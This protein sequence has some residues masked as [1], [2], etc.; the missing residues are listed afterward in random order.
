MQAVAVSATRSPPSYLQRGT[1]IL[2]QVLRDHF[3]R[4]AANYD[5]RYAKDLGNFRLDRISRVATRFLTCGD[6]P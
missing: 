4:F 6:Y 1:S 5:S 2:Q 3:E